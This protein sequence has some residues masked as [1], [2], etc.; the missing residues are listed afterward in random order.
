[1]PRMS[2]L[3]IMMQD[4]LRTDESVLYVAHRHVIVL[5]FRSLLP[6]LVFAGSLGVLWYRVNRPPVIQPLDSISIIAIGIALLALLVLLYLYVDWRKDQIVLTDQRVIYNIEKPLVRRIQEQLPINDI[7]QVEAITSSYPQHWLKY[8]TIEIQSAAFV[9]PMIFRGVSHP[10]R[11]QSRVMRLIHSVKQDE[12]E[13]NDFRDMVQR[14]IYHDEPPQPAHVPTVRQANQPRMLHWLFHENPDYDED[15][16][17]YTWHPHWFFLVK[18]LFRPV[19]FGLLVLALTFAGAQ[20]GLVFGVWMGIFLLGIGLVILGWIA[21]EIEDHRNDRYILTPSQV[22]DIEK[23]PFGPEN[24]SSASLDSIQNV[25]YT[26][27]LISRILGYGDV[28][29]DLAGSGD[30]LTFYQVPH[31]RDVVSA[32]DSYQGAFNRSQKERNLEDALHLLHSYHDM[33]QQPAT[34]TAANGK[35]STRQADSQQPGWQT[36]DA[37]LQHLL[38]QHT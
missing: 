32:I 35:G 2:E 27:T 6:L 8:G 7:H 12:V 31:P 21:W 38:Q 1:M 11:L 23:Q 5:I 22:I 37:L 9:R 34:D 3:S 29:L 17:T 14:R 25:T 30:R 18:Q 19:M 4:E 10:Q 20:Y 36:D 16:H 24:Q 28:W 15:S 13:V 26:T 33:Q